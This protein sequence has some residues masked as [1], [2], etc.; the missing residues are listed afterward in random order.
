MFS[1][2]GGSE[3]LPPP[4]LLIPRVSRVG[5]LSSMQSTVQKSSVVD[6]GT[7]EF[8]PWQRITSFIPHHIETPSKSL[9]KVVGGWYHGHDRSYQIVP[10]RTR[11]C[12]RNKPCF[13]FTS[14]VSFSP[15]PPPKYVSTQPAAAGRRLPDSLSNGRLQ[16]LN[17]VRMVRVAVRLVCRTD[18]WRRAEATGVQGRWDLRCTAAMTVHCHVRDAL[19]VFR[20]IK[21]GAACSSVTSSSR[22]CPELWCVRGRVCAAC[23]LRPSA[24][25]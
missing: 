14:E 16:L 5:I 18:G 3:A 23:A 8:R 1:R 13:L 10:S 15:P 25:Q 12:G 2:V 21:R 17:H 11:I 9:T 7:T 20:W 6:N 24:W 4:R 22:R 19:Q